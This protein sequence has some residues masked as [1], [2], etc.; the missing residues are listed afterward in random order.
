[1][2]RALRRPAR[3]H[4]PKRGRLAAEQRCEVLAPHRARWD[5]PPTPARPRR[6]LAAPS[7]APKPERSDDPP[8]YP[9]GCAQPLLFAAL[10]TLFAALLLVLLGLL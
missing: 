9:P 4:P 2:S 1:M 10:L 6:A 3:I 8:I 7:V 5:C